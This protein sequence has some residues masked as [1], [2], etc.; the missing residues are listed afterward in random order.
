MPTHRL[1][2]TLVTYLSDEGE[3]TKQYV[4]PE[5]REVLA[6]TGRLVAEHTGH[7]RQERHQDGHPGR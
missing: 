2:T 4:S 5:Y 3:H 7:G 6:N 1:P